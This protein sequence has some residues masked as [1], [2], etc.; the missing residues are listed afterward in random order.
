MENIYELVRKDQ[1]RR[2]RDAQER[3]TILMSGTKYTRD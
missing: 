1:E 3:L 2:K